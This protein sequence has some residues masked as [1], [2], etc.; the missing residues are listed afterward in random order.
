MTIIAAVDPGL[1]NTGIV[2]MDKDRVYATTTLH[3]VGKTNSWEETRSRAQKMAVDIVSF[4]R[5]SE[6]EHAIVESFE[7]QSYKG[8]TKKSWATVLVLAYL[9]V[10][11][12]GAAVWQTPSEALKDTKDYRDLW[13]A[14]GDKGAGILLG[15]KA[16]TN[17]HLRSAASHG[18]YYL[19]MEG[20][21]A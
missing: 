8:V 4:I 10:A 17:E 12:S 18:I 21:R 11:L 7:Q 20:R 19:N 3:S 2:V 14:C 15:D 1:A 5:A 13:K 6:A 9:D 16:I